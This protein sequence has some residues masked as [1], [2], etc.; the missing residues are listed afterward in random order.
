MQKAMPTR[1]V[2]LEVV[3]FRFINLQRHVWNG[4][5][6]Q[7]LHPCAALTRHQILTEGFDAGDLAFTARDVYALYKAMKRHYPKD[8]VR[9]IKPEK[10]V[11]PKALNERV[12]MQHVT[13]YEKV[14]KD[15]LVELAADDRV[16]ERRAPVV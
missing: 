5:A 6:L 8:K 2:E 16:H 13:D 12:T 14:L 4:D 7:M 11:F 10:V 9:D 15:R 1:P 3:R